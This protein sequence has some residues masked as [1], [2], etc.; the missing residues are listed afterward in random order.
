MLKED[1]GS[2]QGSKQNPQAGE[3]RFRVWGLGFRFGVYDLDLNTA[4][5]MRFWAP[6]LELPTTKSIK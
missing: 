1:L 6:K 2:K 5:F 3:G 4:L